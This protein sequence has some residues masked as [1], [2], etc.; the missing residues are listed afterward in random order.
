MNAQT[1]N[2]D[3]DMPAEIDFSG[4]RRGQFH[5]AGAQ[6]NL[7]VYLDQKVQA[8]LAALASAKGVDYSA[9]INDLLKKDIELIEMAR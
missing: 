5:K 7:P 9:L 6:L 4:A 1:I 2:D 8:T 3:N